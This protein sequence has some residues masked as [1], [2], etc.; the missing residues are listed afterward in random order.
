MK[1]FIW[2]NNRAEAQSGYNDDLVMSFG[3]AMYIRDTALKLSQQG[4]Q[5]TKNALGSMTVNRTEYQGGYGFSQGS[6]NPYHQDMGGQKED[7]RWL[8]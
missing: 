7:I 2:R 8:L 1:T 3:I 6:D 4:L 5:A